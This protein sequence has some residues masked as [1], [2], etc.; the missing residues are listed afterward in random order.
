MRANAAVFAG[1]F[2][3]A[4]LYA[5]K[6]DDGHIA[7]IRPGDVIAPTPDTTVARTDTTRTDTTQ[8]AIVKSDSV[9]FDAIGD[10]LVPPVAPLAAVPTSD[11]AALRAQSPQVPVA[12]IAVKDLVDSFLDRRGSTRQHNAMDIMAARNTP[13]VATVAGTI[14]KLHNSV[15]G[16]LSIYMR[17]QSSRF[18]FMYGHLESYRP[19]LA[20]GANVRRGE[21][22]GFVGTSGNA[23]PTAPHLHF[24]VMRADNPS[25]WWKGTPVNPFLLYRPAK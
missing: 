13:A 7:I 5:T 19:G 12:G 2:L 3:V 16:G 15:A 14:V 6:P 11:I 4:L 23:N 21:I 17:D 18:M 1:A 25:Q 20:E 24:Q 22:I 10:T 8:A 9:L